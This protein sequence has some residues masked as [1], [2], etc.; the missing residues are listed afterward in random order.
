MA[1]LPSGVTGQHRRYRAAE[2]VGADKQPSLLSR[3]RGQ[4]FSAVHC[5]GSDKFRPEIATFRLIRH[6]GSLGL[7]HVTT[8]CPSPTLESHPSDFTPMAESPDETDSMGAPSDDGQ[9]TIRIPNPKVYMARQSQWK[10]RRGKPRVLPACN[11]CVWPNGKD[12]KYT[13]LPTP[14]HRG[15]PRCDRCRIKNLKCDRNLPVCNHCASEEGAECNYTPKKRHKVPE[16]HIALQKEG[17]ASPYA[18]KSASF[19]VS[20][21]PPSDESGEAGDPLAE[22]SSFPARTYREY[23]GDEPSSSHIKADQRVNQPER[24]RVAPAPARKADRP[25]QPAWMSKSNLPPLAPKTSLH[26]QSSSSSSCFLDQRTMLLP[27]RIEPWTNPEFSPL[28]DSV[29]RHLRTANAMEMP[30]RQNF[31]EALATYLKDLAPELKETAALPPDVYAELARA[32]SKG[33]VSTLSPRRLMWTEIHHI[34]SGSDKHHLL[35]LPRDPYFQMDR[36]DE[37]KLRL[38]Y[39]ARMDGTVDSVEQGRSRPSNG[40]EPADGGFQSLE[41]TMAFERV[42]VQT[43]IYDILVYAHRSHGSSSSMLF[44][45]RRVGV[46]TITWPMVEIFTRLCPLCN[47]R[48]K[49]GGVPLGESSGVKR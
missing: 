37:E 13:P 36:A 46:A 33:D 40:K 11:Y 9:L 3:H 29:L 5:R 41:W 45:V 19:L 25:V 4:R 24:P 43:Q 27:T 34:R 14:A 42:P 2:V 49:T 16:E 47:L 44:E 48:A 15:I 12:C 18:T 20:D 21:V 35:L 28:P 38:E 8:T 26:D 1:V 7:S 32:V 17:S 23:V 30:T 6:L 22:K 10:G 31:E 39:V